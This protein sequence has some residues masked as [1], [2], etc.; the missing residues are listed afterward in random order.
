MN[1]KLPLYFFLLFFFAFCKEETTTIEFIGDNNP[2]KPGTVPTI[3]VENYVTR[4]FIDLLGRTPTDEERKENTNLLIEN[5]LSFESREQL[6]LMLQ[7]DDEI[8]KNDISYKS[9]YYQRLYN[10]AKLRLIEGADDSEFNQRIGIA[11]FSL[12]RAR[13]EGDSI[14]VFRALQSIERSQK[15]IDSKLQLEMG[16]IT[17]EEMYARMLDNFA[18]DII[19]MNTFNF[20]NASFDD[21]FYRFPTQAEYNAAFPIIEE[22]IGGILFGKYIENKHEYCRLLTQSLD[23][24]E[25]NVRWVFLTLLGREPIPNELYHYVKILSTEKDFPKFQSLILRTNE[26]AQ[27]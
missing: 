11:R 23:F 19:N 26:Y 18:Y 10:L 17:F 20:I 13:L 1:R 15:V 8:K 3:K 5:K 7:M 16:E 4:L 2:P 27:F 25:G 14:A 12:T 21:L 9:E 6:I 24:Y 22:S